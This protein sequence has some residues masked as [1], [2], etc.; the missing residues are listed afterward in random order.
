LLIEDNDEHAEWI[1]LLVSEDREERFEI[2]RVA[3]LEQAMIHLSKSPPDVVLLDLGMPEL[4]GYRSYAAV[5]A[6][7][8]STPVVILTGDESWLSKALTLDS[9]VRDYLLKSSI[10]PQQLRD[11]LRRAF[12]SGKRK[13]G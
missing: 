11:A 7:T 6:V 8:L 13:A 12:Q 9:G 2:E 5:R 4:E 3:S 10:S 1:S